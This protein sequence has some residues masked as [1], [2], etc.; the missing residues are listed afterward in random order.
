[1]SSYERNGALIVLL[2]IALLALL[3]QAFS[4]V[5]LSA[6]LS[7]PG[8]LPTATGPPPGMMDPRTRAHVEAAEQWRQP[9]GLAVAEHVVHE[10]PAD[11]TD[12]RQTPVLAEH[13][14]ET[15][16]SHHGGV[17]PTH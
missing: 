8:S 17:A 13:Y 15:E 14:A 5:L 9:I 4:F 1:V 11:S 7:A 12:R 2:N 10:S 16:P 3:Y 6:T